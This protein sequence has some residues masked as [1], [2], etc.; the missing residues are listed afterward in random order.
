MNEFTSRLSLLYHSIN[1]LVFTS[2]HRDH[3]YIKGEI[4]STRMISLGI[5]T[6]LKQEY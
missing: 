4:T 3:P 5:S 1:T 6:E 2:K